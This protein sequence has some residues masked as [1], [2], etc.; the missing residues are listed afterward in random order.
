M[1]IIIFL[2]L[3]LVYKVEWQIDNYYENNKVIIGKYFFLHVCVYLLVI[4]WRLFYC[5]IHINCIY[6]IFLSKDFCTHTH[7]YVRTCTHK[8]MNQFVIQRQWY[9]PKLRCAMKFFS[10]RDDKVPT[11]VRTYA[12]IYE[13]IKACFY[14]RFFW[15]IW[16]RSWKIYYFWIH[17]PYHTY[18]RTPLYYSIII[19]IL[20]R[21]YAGVFFLN[22]SRNI[23]STFSVPV[24]N[25]KYFFRLLIF[26]RCSTY[27]YCFHFL[28]NNA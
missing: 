12:R 8:C 18:L 21:I 7:A 19:I 20:L 25:I 23:I 28:Y 3:D 11:Y 17:T 16:Y 5:L 26:V 27:T 13:S 15:N 22:T 14:T 4:F 6:V 9:F 24:H 2:L 1:F 10:Q